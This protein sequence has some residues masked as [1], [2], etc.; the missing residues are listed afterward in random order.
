MSKV[1]ITITESNC[2]SNYHKKGDT[3]T[4]GD[5]CPEM[6]HELWHCM[7]PYVLALQNG[8][9]L[10]SGEYSKKSFSVKCPD[11]GRV[12]AEVIVEEG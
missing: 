11:E 10:E 4:V 2:R 12:T 6:C 1:K 3:F 9:T 7:Y 8:A 5:L